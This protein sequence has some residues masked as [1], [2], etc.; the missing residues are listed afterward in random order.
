M[1]KQFVHQSFGGPPTPQALYAQ[2]W[3]EI[4]K[5]IKRVESLLC[6]GNLI[7]VSGQIVT[8]TVLEFVIFELLRVKNY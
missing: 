3:G 5:H 6:V 7:I 4:Q 1:V 8:K 2:M